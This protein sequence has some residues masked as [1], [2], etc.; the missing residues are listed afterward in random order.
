MVPCATRH[1]TVSAN[2]V[3]SYLWCKMEVLRLNMNINAQA[4]KNFGDFL[5]RVGNR[6]E[7]VVSDDLINS[8]KQMVVPNH[9]W[10]NCKEA[11][12]DD[13]FPSII[14]NS[15]SGIPPDNYFIKIS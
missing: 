8:P 10:E 5:L 3:K 15:S 9:N 14:Q 13:V 2:L 11:L 4:D 12:I 7:Q 1:E 6:D